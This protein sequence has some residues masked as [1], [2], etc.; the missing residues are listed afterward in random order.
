MFQS[1]GFLCLLKPIHYSFN[2]FADAPHLPTSQYKD[3]WMVFWLADGMWLE[4]YFIFLF[5]SGRTAVLVRRRLQVNGHAIAYGPVTL[6]FRVIALE[7]QRNLENRVLCPSF[8]SVILLHLSVICLAGDSL[9]RPPLRIGRTPLWSVTLVDE[10]T[11]NRIVDLFEGI[12][13]SRLSGCFLFTLSEGCGGLWLVPLIIFPSDCLGKEDKLDRRRP[14]LL[15]TL[16]CNQQNVNISGIPNKQLQ[17][18]GWFVLP[19][20][21][22]WLMHLLDT[23]RIDRHREHLLLLYGEY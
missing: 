9:V 20:S 21:S 14:S 3:V 17:K 11:C 6:I 5:A 4:F 16:S 19:P 18:R 12:E 23:V 1:A 8:E 7:R 13:R 15:I 2:W 22:L 10:M